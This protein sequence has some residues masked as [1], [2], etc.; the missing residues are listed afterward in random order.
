MK[1]QYNCS[2][3]KKYADLASESCQEANV[4][5]PDVAD[6]IDDMRNCK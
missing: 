3:A 4:Y 6:F 5:R 2:E 1:K